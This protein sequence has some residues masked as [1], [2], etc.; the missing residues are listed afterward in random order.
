MVQ[1]HR[2]QLTA[3][4]SPYVERLIGSVRRECVNQ[5]IVLNERHLRRILTEYFHYYHH[6]RAHLSLDQYSPVTR[7]VERRDRG[8]LIAI[9]Q[10]GG[11]HYRYRRMA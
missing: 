10:V 6:A 8:E 7:D 5:F 4:A 3:Q 2:V 11:L 9:P 1:R